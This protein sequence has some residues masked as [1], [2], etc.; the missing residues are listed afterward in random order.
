MNFKFLPLPHGEVKQSTGN[1]HSGIVVV[2]T[3]ATYG[4]GNP[5]SSFN[6]EKS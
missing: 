2:P 4:S 5:N 6:N 3:F 1:T